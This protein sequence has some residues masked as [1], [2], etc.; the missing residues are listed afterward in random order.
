MIDA[1]KLP[2]ITLPALNPLTTPIDPMG[3][4][5]LTMFFGMIVCVVL[6]MRKYLP[7]IGWAPALLWGYA[8][9][10]ALF[11]L[12]F[13]DTP[14]GDYNRAFEATAGRSFAEM[15]LIPLAAAAAPKIVWRV[16]PWLVLLDIG[17][18]WCDH[19]AFTPWD[20]V[21]TSFDTATMA[22]FIP[23]SPIWLWPLSLLT[24]VTHHGST[25]LLILLAECFAL[26]FVKLGW[27][28]TFAAI[29]PVTIC[30]FALAYFHSNSAY[31]D[32]SERLHNY[33]RFMEFPNRL[34]NFKVFGVGAGSF[35]WI[36]LMLDNFGSLNWVWM[37]SD[38]LQI[39]FDL[40]R[41]GLALAIATFA[42]AIYRVR[43]DAQ[44]LAAVL[45]AGAFMGP[46]HPL[47]FFPTMFFIALIAKSALMKKAP[48]SLPELFKI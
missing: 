32:G 4:W 35:Q 30:L 33:A 26:F 14:F 21:S 27:K 43:D 11:V 44:L 23:F 9:S 39:T 46:Y 34:W 7:Y 24:I 25:A 47:R 13:P 40:G 42:T 16:I 2:P 3:I 17:L 6:L 37:L 15:L 18:V 48:E 22:L 19:S 36:S 45:G 12:E 41:V 28:K 29:L 38:W 5:G 31:L 10:N 20:S 8:L 1:S